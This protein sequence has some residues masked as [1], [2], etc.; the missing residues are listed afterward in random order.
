MVGVGAR[1]H[2]QLKQAPAEAG[3]LYQYQ[4]AGLDP[5]G[6]YRAYSLMTGRLNLLHRKYLRMFMQAPPPPAFVPLPP[7][8]LVPTACS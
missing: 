6:R 5:T 3:E 2:K 1:K 4:E 7:R 8:A